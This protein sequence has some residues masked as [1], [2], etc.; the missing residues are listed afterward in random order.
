MDGV[1]L[2]GPGQ[3]LGDLFDPVAVR[4]EQ[5]HVSRVTVRGPGQEVVEQLLAVRHAAID[6]HQLP[7]LDGLRIGPKIDTLNNRP[8]VRRTGDGIPQK[9]FRDPAHGHP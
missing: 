6:E 4:S 3:H 2:A 9:R 1:Q 8:G 5:H 7:V